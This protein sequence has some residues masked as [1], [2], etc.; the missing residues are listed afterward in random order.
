[1]PKA[2][3]EKKAPAEKK[4]TKRGASPYNLFMKS[5]LAKVKAEKPDLSHKEAFKEAASRWATA[6]ENPKN[7]K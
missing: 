6:K 1:M 2:A 3:A 5:E 7:Q 4:T